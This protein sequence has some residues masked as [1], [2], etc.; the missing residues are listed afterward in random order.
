MKQTAVDWLV[1]QVENFNCMKLGLIPSNIV[2]KAKEMEKEQMLGVSKEGIFSTHEFEQYYKETYEEEEPIEDSKI[3]KRI[4]DMPEFMNSI[5]T[6]T[7]KN[8]N[9]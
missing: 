1:D 5:G 7:L 8:L 6:D 2:E 9:E 4:S 3:Y